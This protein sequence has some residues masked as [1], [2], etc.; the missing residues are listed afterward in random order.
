MGEGPP[1]PA[2]SLEIHA[3]SNILNCNVRL[4]RSTLTGKITKVWGIDNSK[5]PTIEILL[6]ESH[7]VLLRPLDIDITK[8]QE[9]QLQEPGDMPLGYT[10]TG[11]RETLWSIRPS[12]NLMP[13]EFLDTILTRIPFNEHG[14]PRNINRAWS[15]A[16]K[17]LQSQRQKQWIKLFLWA[18][19]F[20]TWRVHVA[21]IIV[22]RKLVSTVELQDF[23]T[24]MS[25]RV[26]GIIERHTKQKQLITR[27]TEIGALFSSMKLAIC[28][29]LAYLA[30]DGGPDCCRRTFISNWILFTPRNT[31]WFNSV[32]AGKPY[33]DL[34]YEQNPEQDELDRETMISINDPYDPSNDSISTLMSGQFG[35]TTSTS[36]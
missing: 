8:D 26:S 25:T 24:L 20:Y 35:R 36:N 7:F 11:L 30:E 31:T 1:P 33:L 6:H 14:A 2:G 10:D 32:S 19:V 16:A 3:L 9:S 4:Y 29:A 17:R 18:A 5:G 28:A 15:S 21:D 12:D 27:R 23:W 13:T 22:T 34:F